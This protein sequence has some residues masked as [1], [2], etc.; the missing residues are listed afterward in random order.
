MNLMILI[1]LFYSFTIILSKYACLCKWLEAKLMPNLI[2]QYLL[3]FLI[4]S[5]FSF[6]VGILLRFEEPKF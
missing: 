4:E 2:W 5:Y 3:T 6:A 1:Y